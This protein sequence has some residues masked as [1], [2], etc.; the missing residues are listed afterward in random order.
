MPR[1]SAYKTPEASGVIGAAVEYRTGTQRAAF[2]YIDERIR[3]N[4]KASWCKRNV[5]DGCHARP[6][7]PCRGAGS[8]GSADP[9]WR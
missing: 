3:A 2:D 5:K 6:R 1:P 8:G 9:P 7:L 4:T